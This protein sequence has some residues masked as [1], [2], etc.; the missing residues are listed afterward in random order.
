MVIVGVD[1]D[2]T[3]RFEIDL[4]HGMHLDALAFE[5]GYIVLRPLEARIVDSDLR[6]RLL[7]RPTAGEP[8][9]VPAAPPI[10]RE[11]QLR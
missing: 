4:D 8:G 5:H 9:P 7:V 2:G 6:L 11:W 10:C 1:G 3:T